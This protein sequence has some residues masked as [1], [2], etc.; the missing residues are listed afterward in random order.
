MLKLEPS[1]ADS[2]ERTSGARV[3]VVDDEQHMCDICARTLRRAGYEVITTSDPMQAVTL[4]RDGGGF[5]LLLTD[6]KMPPMSGFDL[7]HVA[8]DEDPA[9]AIIIMTGFASLENLQQ[10]VQRG[11]ADFLA[12]PFELDQLRL[13]VDQALHKRTLLQDNVRLRAVEQLL[14]QSE[15]LNATLDTGQIAELLLTIALQHAQCSGGA[16]LLD[17]EGGGLLVGA[18]QPSG[19]L[20]IEAGERLAA[21]A[22]QTLQIAG[23]QNQEV[24]TLGGAALRHALALPIR[25]QGDVNGVLLL[26][27]DRPIARRAAVQ[28]ILEL[29]ATSAGAALRNAMLYRQLNDAYRRLQELDRTKSEFIAIASHEL[30]TPLAII[31]GYTSMLRDQETSERRDFVQR[32]LQSAQRIKDIVDDMVSLR[33]LETGEVMLAADLCDL[34]VVTTHAIDRAQDASR[35]R[36][37]ELLLEAPDEGLSFISDSDRVQLVLGHL[38]SNAVKFTPEGGRVTLNAAVQLTNQLPSEELSWIVHP[39]GDVSDAWA[40]FR[41]TDTG[42]GIVEREHR[43]IFERF[44]QVADSLTRDHGGTGLGLAVVRELVIKLG[45]ALWVK[46][47]VGAGSTFGVALPYLQSS[48]RVTGA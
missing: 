17:A 47:T 11:V 45:G 32:V 18:A 6:I 31:M 7:A 30:R 22:Q 37:Q 42:I 12:K 21:H 29:L 15:R 8:R 25:A 4:L 24:A 23:G 28:E 3:L 38:L 46:S 26:C 2:P 13:A 1:A 16:V 9:I 33:H 10:S 48:L 27:S 14:A 40:V 41:V 39:R 5:D 20:V 36:N 19:L 43:R 34:R 44:Y 35:A